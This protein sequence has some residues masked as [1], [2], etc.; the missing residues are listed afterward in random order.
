M[1]LN[2]KGSHRRQR[3]DASYEFNYTHTLQEYYIDG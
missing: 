3:Y 1:I 2:V